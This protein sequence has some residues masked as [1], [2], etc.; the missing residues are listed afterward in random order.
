MRERSD[1]RK[2]V[3]KMPSWEGEDLIRVLQRGKDGPRQ[4]LF[5]GAGMLE[6]RKY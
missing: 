1:K 3:I 2:R 5:R 6:F 4:L